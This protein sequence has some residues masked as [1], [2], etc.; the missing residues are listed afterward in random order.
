MTSINTLDNLEVAYD[1]ADPVRSAGL[2]AV[3]DYVTP[4]W[5]TGM[6]PPLGHWLLFPPQ[7]R[8]S[9]LGADGHPIF[10]EG[11]LLPKSDL[12]RR[13]WAGSRIQFLHDIPL[14]ARLVRRSSLASVTPKEGRSG[15]LLF[16][17]VRHEVEVDGTGLAL[18][19]EQDLVYREAAPRS[20]ALTLPS[21]EAR[22]PR[23]A[24]PT[25]TVSVKTPN[26]VMVFRFSAL[27]FNS[28][29]I[30]Y[31]RDYARNVEG[32]PDMVV[33]GPLVATLLMDHLLNQHPRADVTGFEFRAV[34]PLFVGEPLEL[35]SVYGEHGEDAVNLVA[36][37]SSGLGMTATARITAR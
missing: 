1:I 34:A 19:E 29:R 12:P 13:M 11:G 26:E 5:K 14:N 32:Y 17:T 37:A 6:L 35:V 20:S 23:T 18:V 36:F 27:A 8:Q 28:H 2:A 3:L 33:Q 9:S 10:E 7:V 21:V 22:A 16:V 15:R 25:E 31:D 30:H 4:P 24:Q